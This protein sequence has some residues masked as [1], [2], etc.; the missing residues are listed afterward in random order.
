[1]VTTAKTTT[2]LKTVIDRISPSPEE[3]AE[4]L[5]A[6]DGT[7][8]KLQKLLKGLP[9]KVLAAGSGKKHTQL[10][11]ARETDLFVL[12]NYR[13]YAD[14]HEE[15]SD[16]LW[17]RLKGNFKN[18]SRLHGSR[19]YFQTKTQSR[20]FEIVPILEIK[21]SAQARNITDIT[22]LHTRWVSK[23]SKGKLG[24]IRLTKAFLAAL[25]IYGAESYIRGF[26]GYACEILTIHYGSFTKLLRAAIKWKDK[27]IIDPAGF[28][29][30]RNPLMEM[31]KSKLTG[32]LVLVDPVQSGRNVTAALNQ[33]S[34]AKF[35]QAA[36]KFLKRPSE[37]F[38]EIK[39]LTEKDLVGSVDRKYSLL[40]LEITPEKNKKDAMGAA[41]LDKYLCVRNGLSERRFRIKKSSWFWD[42]KRA[43]VW[44]I[45]SKKFP[46]P[47]ET[48]KGPKVSDAA[49][50]SRF[51]RKHK[52]AFVKNGRLYASE[53]RKF[54]SPDKLVRFMAARPAFMRR[55]KT[56]KIKWHQTKSR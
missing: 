11:N 2:L 25:G 51:R 52:N 50:S 42:E 46:P 37:K 7:I 10:K 45:L 15:I 33:E 20:V 8:K 39:T 53:K 12:F 22:P 4:T 24:E 43:T 1:M 54:A 3:T 34:F 6:A 32:P 40:L 18:L 30:R 48:R 13:K 47:H 56:L 9:V 31:N 38:F 49:N 27:Q 44:F 41:I 23:N 5:T 19:D 17:K 29:R 26:S 14:R 55:L 35:R 28:Y 36:S 21:S 16:V